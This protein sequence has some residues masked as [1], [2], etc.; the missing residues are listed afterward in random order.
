M[1]A[2]AAERR[3]EIKKYPNRRLYDATRSCHVTTDD[4]YNLIRDGYEV[5]VTDSKSAADITNLVLTQ[6]ILER[7]PPKLDVFPAS[8][9]HEVIRSN[10]Q[11]WRSF[12][13]RF[14]GQA[15]DAF[16]ASQRQFD[17]YVRQAMT[18]GGK[19][20]DPF[21]WTRSMF[22]A[23]RPDRP[24]PP[25]KAADSAITAATPAA[26][27]MEQTLQEL[28]QR[29]GELSAEVQSLRSTPTRRAARKTGSPRRRE[30]GA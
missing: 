1:D 25:A 5:V 6:M 14:F 16:A 18:L 20:M 11:M 8:I 19:A 12:V 9:L 23:M 15:M 21:G 7:D 22:D 17:N 10:Q 24:S 4:L 3:L 30:S 29:V 28:R 13:D 27:D 26:S 2:D